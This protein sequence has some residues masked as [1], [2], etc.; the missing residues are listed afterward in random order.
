MENIFSLLFVRYE[1][2]KE[3]ICSD[4][5]EG[6]IDTNQS[7]QNDESF[8]TEKVYDILSSSLTSV[9]NTNELG[10]KP[11][12]RKVSSSNSLPSLSR[13]K[14]W[15]ESYQQ[16]HGFVC[17]RFMTRDILKLLQVCIMKSHCVNSAD[18]IDSFI[19]DSSSSVIARYEALQKKVSTA[20]WK[21]DTLLGSNFVESTG[22]T[23]TVVE[24]KYLPDWLFQQYVDEDSASDDESHTAVLATKGSKRA[25]AEKSSS[26][27]QSNLTSE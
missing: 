4:S 14:S 25:D 9:A 23:D 20:L 24:K 12:N 6:E 26:G 19:E 27:S 10:H 11:F 13:S 17:D 1:D 15:H 3:D 7:F 8:M 5:E 22:F 2:F 16:K 21:L 18:Q